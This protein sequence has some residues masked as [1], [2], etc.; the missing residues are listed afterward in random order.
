MAE[1]R[2]RHPVPFAEYLPQ[3]EV[4]APILDALGFL[5]LIPRDYSVDPTSANAFDVAGTIAGVAICF[6][7]I[8][9]ALAREMV[10]DHGAE[11]ILAPTNNADFGRGSAE[12]VQQLAI[13]QLRAVEAGRALVNISTVG[14]SAVIG[15]S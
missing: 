5:E 12:N 8:D 14:T 2:K 7:I 9:D 6:D 1:Y 15:P 10:L 4:F 3:R 11:I 13:A